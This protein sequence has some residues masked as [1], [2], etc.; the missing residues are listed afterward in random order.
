M[1]VQLCNARLVDPTHPLNG[2]V[3]NLHIQGD[4]LVSAEAVNQPI[5]LRMDM[6]GCIAMA[7]AI[8]LHTHIGGGK[9]NLARMLM[10]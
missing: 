6:H 7:G 8:D 2:Q 10:Q 9:L 3:T 5:A 4:R 1:I